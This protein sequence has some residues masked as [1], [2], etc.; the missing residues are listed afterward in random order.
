[1]LTQLSRLCHM[2]LTFSQKNS[3]NIWGSLSVDTDNGS[4]VRFALF[5]SLFV[6][7][8]N[9]LHVE[10]KMI[11]QLLKAV[12]AISTRRVILCFTGLKIC[13]WPVSLESSHRLSACRFS[14][15]KARSN[16]AVPVRWSSP[17][18]LWHEGT[19]GRVADRSAG[20]QWGGRGVLSQRPR[21]L[22]R[23]VM[24]SLFNWQIWQRWEQNHNLEKKKEIQL[25]SNE[26]QETHKNCTKMSTISWCI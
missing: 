12:L 1:M 19:T 9:Y 3:E 2:E 26:V 11:F 18:H 23:P 14:C 22:W 16:N 20:R 13:L 5:M 8:N 24:F 17:G 6:T 25:L 10:D 21:Q 4:Y 7:E 15:F